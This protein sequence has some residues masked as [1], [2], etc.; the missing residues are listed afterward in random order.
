MND[1]AIL[2]VLERKRALHPELRARLTWNGFLAILRRER[3]HLLRVPLARPGKLL[4]FDGAWTILVDASRPA[5]HLAYGCHELAHLWL[6]VDESEGRFEVCYNMDDADGDDPRESEA[7]FLA[8]CLIE[9]PEP[10]PSIWRQALRRGGLVVFLTAWLMGCGAV[11]GDVFTEGYSGATQ[12]LGGRAVVLAANTPDLRRE[13]ARRCDSV[14]AAQLR[15]GQEAKRQQDLGMQLLLAPRQTATVQRAWRNTQDSTRR[16]L[17]ALDHVRRIDVAGL[18]LTP[19]R[20]VT[21]DMRGHYRFARVPRGHYFLAADG[22][23]G[24]MSVPWYTLV[25]VGRFGTVHRDLSPRL[26]TPV[27]VLA[28]VGGGAAILDSFMPTAG[29]ATP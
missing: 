12:P 13:I 10:R 24:A 7:E 11:E 21:T 19:L 22:G 14:D 18:T 2:R 9:G 1:D 28:V 6:H 3:V 25:D 27:C 8:A 17:A 29:G 20:H 5:R 15:L 26:Q 4:G 16:L 23:L